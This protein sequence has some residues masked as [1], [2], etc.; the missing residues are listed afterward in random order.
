MVAKEQSKKKLNESNLEKQKNESISNKKKKTKSFIVKKKKIPV[1]S[2]KIRVPYRGE[3][4]YLNKYRS[5]RTDLKRDNYPRYW[6]EKLG[7][8]YH[9]PKDSKGKENLEKAAIDGFSDGRGMTEK[10]RVFYHKMVNLSKYSY[11]SSEQFKRLCLGCS[12]TY[13]YPENI[14]LCRHLFCDMEYNLLRIAIL[15]CKNAKRKTITESDVYNAIYVLT[16]EV[17]A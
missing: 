7:I 15:F 8:D 13:N 1:H 9:A 4:L 17:P 16:G 6:A 12:I 11:I 10:Q 3:N 2:K 14:Q 5:F